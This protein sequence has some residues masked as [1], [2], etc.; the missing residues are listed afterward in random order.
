[1]KQRQVPHLEHPRK[2]KPAGEALVKAKASSLENWRTERG[3]KD[4]GG[5]DRGGNW[6]A[7]RE[8]PCTD[9]WPCWRFGLY[10]EFLKDSNVI[11]LVVAEMGNASQRLKGSNTLS[12]IGG[13]FGGGLKRIKNWWWK[14]GCCTG[15]P[16]SCSSCFLTAVGTSCLNLSCPGFHTMADCIPSNCKPK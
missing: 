16:T 6:A 13:P 8:Q 15:Q 14:W 2:Q 5:G 12:L 10:H 4:K 9:P 11:W 1:M 3:W 7:G